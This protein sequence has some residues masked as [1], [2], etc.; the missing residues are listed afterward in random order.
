MRIVEFDII[1]FEDNK[2]VVAGKKKGYFHSFGIDYEPLIDGVGQY[3][4]ALIETD[5]GKVHSIPVD[6]F[7]FLDSCKF[8]T[9]N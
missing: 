1:K 9:S 8:H 4:I 7:R 2:P 6:N 5:D 3:S